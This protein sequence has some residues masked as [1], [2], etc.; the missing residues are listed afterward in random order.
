MELGGWEFESGSKSLVREFNDR[1]QRSNPL[2]AGL[3]E[4]EPFNPHPLIL[5]AN[6][7]FHWA[8]LFYKPP[9]MMENNE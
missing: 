1:T 6:N 9:K 7:T 4:L 5:T 8:K 3:W 2:G